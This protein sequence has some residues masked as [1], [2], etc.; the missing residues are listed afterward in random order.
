MVK[1]HRGPAPTKLPCVFYYYDVDAPM[2]TRLGATAE[3][4]TNQTF[5]SRCHNS[6]S[7][8]RRIHHNITTVFDNAN[9]EGRYHLNRSTCIDMQCV[10]TSAA[11]LL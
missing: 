8:L 5:A 6:L 10:R 9:F 7:I 3:F 11:K 1:G 4:L 2:R